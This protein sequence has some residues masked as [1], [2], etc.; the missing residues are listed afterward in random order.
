M[1]ARLYTTTRK[2]HRSYYIRVPL[3]HPL[4]AY[5]G[6]HIKDM[7]LTADGQLTL[8]IEPAAAAAAGTP[9]SNTNR[10]AARAVAA[11]AT[12]ARKRTTAG[13]RVPKKR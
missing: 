2:G 10:A 11:V 4:A 6:R 1:T 12:A 8:S 7:A 3:S 5:V 13:G 9:T